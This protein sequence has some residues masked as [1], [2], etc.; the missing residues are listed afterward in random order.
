M[1]RFGYFKGLPY[2]NCDESFLDYIRFS[3]QLPK[4]KILKHMETLHPRSAPFED[5]DILTGEPVSAGTVIDGTFIFPMDFLHYYRNYKIGIP[6]EY[7]AYIVKVLKHPELA[8]RK[9]DG[10]KGPEEIN[11]KIYWGFFYGIKL[12]NTSESFEDYQALHNTLPK[13]KILEHMESVEV[14]YACG[15]YTDC[16]VFD[17]FTGQALKVGICTDGQFVFPYAFLHYYRNY[18]IGVPA[19]YE[20]YLRT[21][22][23]SENQEG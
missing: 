7:E 20:D 2:E 19:I 10:I 16:I 6:Y 12:D 23:F 8:Q 22:I 5:K 1:F 4:E 21:V 17:I 14:A 13:E 15:C 9:L 11:G 3:N 18:D